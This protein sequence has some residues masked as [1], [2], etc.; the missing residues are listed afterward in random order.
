VAVVGCIAELLAV[1]LVVITADV[2]HTWVN[3]RSS[4]RYFMSDFHLTT[5]FLREYLAELTNIPDHHTMSDLLDLILSSNA[6]FLSHS[7]IKI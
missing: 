6:Y 7:A 5:T 1:D 4:S 3:D 2:L